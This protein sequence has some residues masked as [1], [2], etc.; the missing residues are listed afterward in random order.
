KDSRR[1]LLGQPLA[2]RL[3][4]RLREELPIG[5]CVP[6]REQLLGAT[7]RVAVQQQSGLRGQLIRAAFGDRVQQRVPAR[8]DSR[9]VGLDRPSRRPYVE[10]VVQDL[11]LSEQLQ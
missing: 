1:L 9:R 2:V 8:G 4:Q 5:S 11:L 7:H 10:R 6:I 3:E